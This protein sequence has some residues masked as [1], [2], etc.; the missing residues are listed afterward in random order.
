MN[1]QTMKT[2]KTHQARLPRVVKASIA[3]SAALFAASALQAQNTDQNNPPPATS[4]PSAAAEASATLS[5][6][7]KEFL[8][9]AG[10]ANQ[11]EIAMANVAESKSQNAQVKDLATMMS[12]DHQAN[13]A[14]VQSIAQ[15]HG[16][17]LETKLDM[18]NQH[19]VNRLQ[20]A[21]DADFDKEYTTLMIKDHVKCLKRFDK[22][23]SD[24]EEQDVKQYAQNTLPALRHH[25]KKS[26][27]A[28]RS[29]GVD[30]ATIDSLVKDLPSEDRA[31]TVR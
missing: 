22:A 25:L 31:V 18:L 13:F 19:E 24:I 14:L 1:T 21:D 5:H 2:H 3:L 12:T 28:A 11:T 10:Q 7:A 15:A 16:I 8:K 29:A 17:T 27:E 20:R 9:D 6:R 4:P 30:Q 26:E 23:A